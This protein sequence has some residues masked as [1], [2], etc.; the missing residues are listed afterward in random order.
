MIFPELTAEALVAAIEPDIYVKG[1]DWGAG[2]KTAPEVVVVEAYGGRVVLPAVSAWPFD[3]RDYHANPGALAAPVK[4]D[5][6]ST[7]LASG[8]A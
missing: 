1:G 7:T 5:G 4:D 3:Q 6:T 2:Q 8:S